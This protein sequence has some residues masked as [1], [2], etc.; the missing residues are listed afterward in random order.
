MRFPPPEQAQTLAKS[1]FD[2]V[3]DGDAHAAL[4]Y[5]T[6][7][8]DAAQF[9]HFIWKPLS[10]WGQ[11]AFG[12][13]SNVRF[14][15]E[16]PRYATRHE[17]Y[18]LD[19]P[20]PLVEQLTWRADA[21]GKL[22]ITEWIPFPVPDQARKRKVLTQLAPAFYRALWEGDAA[23][24]DALFPPADA[25]E[26]LGQKIIEMAAPAGRLLGMEDALLDPEVDDPNQIRVRLLVQY[27]FARQ[28]EELNFFLS[29]K[30]DLHLQNW[31]PGENQLPAGE[32]NDYQP[33]QS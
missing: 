22:Y 21:N 31:R 25:E 8:I 14:I 4:S 1:Y 33:V 24:L 13:H 11:G 16:D 28:E 26:G 10:S 29:I 30:G 17:R 7:G 23:K 6:H 19:L 27:E 9:N 12:M 32:R 2:A 3:D 18:Y 15:E 20:F 5:W